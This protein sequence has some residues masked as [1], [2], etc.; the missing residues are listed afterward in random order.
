MLSDS[1]LATLRNRFKRD[2]EL[3]MQ[4]S[5]SPVED[6][7]TR[8]LHSTVTPAKHCYQTPRQTATPTKRTVIPIPIAKQKAT[9]ITAQLR[10]DIFTTLVCKMYLA[11]RLLA[12]TYKV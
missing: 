10:T 7:K 3:L 12:F 9:E 11:Y 5:T 6:E 8:K 2:A 1:E 4:T